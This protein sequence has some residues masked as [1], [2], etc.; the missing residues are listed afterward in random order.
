MA[1][2]ANSFI[3]YRSY[4]EAL[5]VLP[6]E[7]QLDYLKAIFTYALDGVEPEFKTAAER[8]MFTLMKAN[9]DSCDKRYKTSVE[10]GKKGGAP[11]GNSNASK[12][13][14]QP[15]KQPNNNLKNNLN[16]TQNN[17]NKNDNDNV[18]DNYHSLSSNIS[19]SESERSLSGAPSPREQK[20]IKTFEMAGVRYEM[21][22]DDSGKKIVR[23]IAND[24][25]STE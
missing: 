19:P 22:Y 9:L 6:V 20:E 14:K 11:K 18:N 13:E 7:V 5:E 21:F 23:E 16:S 3:F 12:T 8:G 10:N 4:A 24:R 2:K 1:D 17:L 25:S 15:K